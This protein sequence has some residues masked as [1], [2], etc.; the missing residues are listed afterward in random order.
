MDELDKKLFHD[1]SIETDISKKLDTIIENGL[2]KKIKKYSYLRITATICS[3]LAITSGIVYAG[4]NIYE[5]IWKEPQ[6]IVGGNSEES[7]GQNMINAEEDTLTENEARIKAEEILK[8]FGFINEN[9]KTIELQDNPENFE[10]T[11][12]ISTENNI[13]ISFNANDPTNFSISNRNIINEDIEQYRSTEIEAKET[14]K[15]FCEKYGYDPDDYNCIKIS[16]N[17]NSEKE[18]YIWYVEF[19]KE[20]DGII[21][22]YESIS[23]GFIPDINKIYYFTVTNKNFDDNP[24]VITE[25]QAI[26]ISLK[27][28][29]EINTKYE[30]KNI[31]SKLGIISMNGIAYLRTNEYEQLHEQTSGNYPYE[32]YIN[33][34]TN[35]CVRKAWIV[36]I[37]YDIPDSVDKSDSSSYNRNDEQ[38]SYYIDA[39]TGEV[40]GG[41][42]L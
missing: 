40:I 2:E 9:I 37:K 29:Q 5:K 32:E 12:I 14:C 42:S 21:N 22:P 30:I 38:F 16:S 1:L 24:L 13:L 20:Y 33:Y 6:R 19:F 28:E 4:S 10:L 23:I 18:S 35:D 15:K 27:Q 41:S 26:D 25:E 7:I 34:R 3:L 11:W 8:K 17:L 39:T 36:T 31:N